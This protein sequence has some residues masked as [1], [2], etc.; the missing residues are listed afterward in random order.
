MYIYYL[1]LLTNLNLL[2]INL[3]LYQAY[4]KNYYIFSILSKENLSIILVN[5]ASKNDFSTCQY[6]SIEKFL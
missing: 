6:L 1:L 5:L 3:D 2:L 4:S